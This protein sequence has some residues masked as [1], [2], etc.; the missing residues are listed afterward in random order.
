M[1]ETPGTPDPPR[2]T[3]RLELWIGEDRYIVRPDGPAGWRL[4]KAG[5][6]TYRIDPDGPSCTCEDF[7]WRRGPLGQ[8]CRHIAAMTAVSLQ[9]GHAGR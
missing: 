7:V 1:A 8:P 2:G 3:A 9:R 4:A 6:A 5:G